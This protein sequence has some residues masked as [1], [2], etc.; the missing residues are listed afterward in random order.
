MAFQE[1]VS[2][3]EGT[4]NAA[5]K[6]TTGL[7]KKIVLIRQTLHNTA[8]TSR[9]LMNKASEIEKKLE[10]II[11]IFEGAEARASS[12]EIPPSAMPLNSRLMSIVY[13]SMSSSSGTTQTQLDNYEILKEEFP[14][15]LD[16]L[17]SIQQMVTELNDELDAI[18]A[19]WTPGRV[20]SL[21]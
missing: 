17:K 15:V 8:G 9:D 10:D 11:F 1:K 12:E 20:P 16:D 6:F 19:P 21:Q 4:M 14:P 3:Q 18:G 7:Q 2:E 13:A 5:E